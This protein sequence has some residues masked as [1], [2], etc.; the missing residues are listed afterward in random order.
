MLDGS[1]QAGPLDGDPE[2]ETLVEL[3]SVGLLSAV[4][5]Q[6]IAA[7]SQKAAP[8]EAMRHLAELGTSGARPGNVHRDLSRKLDLGRMDIP[9]PELIKLSLWDAAATPPIMRDELYPFLLPHEI[10][11]H[12]FEFY[13]MEFR[14]W[15]RGSA[16]LS[17][18][19]AGISEQDPRMIGHPVHDRAGWQY[20][21][22]PIRIHGDAVPVGRSKFRSVDILSFSSM[23]SDRGCTWDTKFPFF[24]IVGGKH[25]IKFSGSTT[26]ESTMCKAWRVILWSFECMAAGVWPSRDWDGNEWPPG[27]RR[28]KAGTRLA[29]DVFFAFF[30]VAA[31]LDYLANYLKMAHFNSKNRPCMRCKANRSNIPWADLRPQALWRQRPVTYTNWQEDENKHAL[32]RN[33]A[34]GLSHYH[35]CLDVLHIMDLGITQS[36]AGSVIYLLIWD[37]S[38][39]G[40]LDTRI[41]QVWG[42]LQLSYVELRTP[43]GERVSHETYAKL[44][45]GSRS[46][47]PTRY[48]ILLSKGAIARHIIPALCL[49]VVALVPG[50]AEDELWSNLFALISE[51]NFFYGICHGFGNYI[52]PDHAA[53]ARA[54]LQ[55]VGLSHHY[56]CDKFMKEGRLLFFLSEKAHYA[57]H[58]ADDMV[59]YNVK[60][61]WTYSDEDFMGKMSQIGTASLR[62]R[63]P[64]R[65][66][67]AMLYRWRHRIYIRWQR[68]AR[69]ES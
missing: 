43:A 29:G 65:L 2:V 10:V 41:D 4:T 1:C 39:V 55:G 7:S 59:W 48:P 18:F 11:A 38:L 19:W 64:F 3:W 23:T 35:V 49:A 67:A 37:A 69:A 36:I 33:R 12:M 22:I 25:G 60:A 32:F 45:E 5:L 34:L 6:Q 68:R 53:R 57:Q 54:A 28:D 30:Q 13:P 20:T 44:F 61:G 24:V 42:A 56:F 14:K 62:A 27:V 50:Y 66:A 47:T 51:L 16:C 26:N 63:G 8:R 21:A 52:P 58:I 17:E 40:D 9:K 31:D 15:I 46:Y